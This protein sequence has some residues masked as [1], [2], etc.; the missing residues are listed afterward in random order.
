MLATTTGLTI[1]DLGRRLSHMD[2]PTH[3]PAH[4]SIAALLLAAGQG[5]CARPERAGVDRP[6]VISF[7]P[8]HAPAQPDLL[9]RALERGSGLKVALRPAASGGQA[10]DDFQSG[11]ADAALLSLFDFLYCAEVFHARP[12][13]Q[14]LR[15][16]GL[17]AYQGELVVR[18]G[19]DLRE[20]AQLQG[21]PVAF[22]DR[23]S[24][25]GFLLPARALREAGVEVHPA[26]LGSHPAVLEAVREGRFPAGATW[27][28]HAQGQPGLRVLAQTPPVANEP[29]FAQAQLPEETRAALRRGLLA[30]QAEPQALAGLAD[31]TGFRSIPEGTY[32]S[33]L[34]TVR[35]AGQSVEALVPGGWVRANEARRPLWSYAP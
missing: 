23:W 6:L 30:L 18:D 12:L 28:G 25:T 16:G 26:W 31:I 10:V 3:T 35:A 5:A 1:G 24:V 8:A 11:R 2:R 19:S 14:A 29:L 17:D 13:A 21:L 15:R 9:A 22:V 33:A 34:A 20:L 4:L 27:R 32:E 7:S